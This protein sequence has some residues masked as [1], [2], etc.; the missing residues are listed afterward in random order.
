VPRDSSATRAKL[1]DAAER[2]MADHGLYVPLSDIAEAAGQR[3]TAAVS[4]HFGNRAG[5]LSAIVAR[6]NV[7]GR[8]RRQAVVE[9][10]RRGDGDVR[11]IAEAVMRPI[12]DFLLGD[13]GQPDY[14]QVI[15][16]LMASTDPALVEPRRH[17]ADGGLAL[18][19]ELAKDRLPEV[20]PSLLEDRIYCAATMAL[21][22]CADRVRNSIDWASSADDDLAFIENI[23]DMTLGAILA[24][25]HRASEPVDSR[26]GAR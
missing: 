24:P 22:L 4:Y 5:L 18:V 16:A 2:L 26:S 7:E 14:L 17:F 15:A 11:V 21:H 8:K 13:A 20:P 6:N 23:T 10:A 19:V 25:S 12:A 9:G 1:L 3:N